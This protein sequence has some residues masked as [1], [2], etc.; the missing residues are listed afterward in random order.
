MSLKDDLK[1]LKNYRALE[2]SMTVSVT[3]SHNQAIEIVVADLIVK[4][5]SCKQ[6]DDEYKDAFAKVLRFY[7]TED[8]FNEIDS[9]TA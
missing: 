2:R 8:E 1:L 5:K 3:I 4:Y 9:I 6:R 7:L